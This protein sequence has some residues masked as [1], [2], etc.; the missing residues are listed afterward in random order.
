M[1]FTKTQ[2]RSSSS[3][4][5]EIKKI[6][7]LNIDLFHNGGLWI[8]SLICMI[9]SLS[10]LVSMCKI[11][12]NSHFQTR[13]ERLI[14][15]R[16]N[17]YINRPP[18]WKRSIYS[19]TQTFSAEVHR[20][21]IWVKRWHNK[22]ENSE[23]YWKT[24]LLLK[25]IIIIIIIKVFIQDF[26]HTLKLTMFIS[27]IEPFKHQLQ[28]IYLLTK[29]NRTK[30]QTYEVEERIFGTPCIFIFLFRTHKHLQYITF[31]IHYNNFSLLVTKF[32]LTL[33]QV[34]VIVYRTD[35]KKKRNKSKEKEDKV[36]KNT[37]NSLYNN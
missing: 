24:Q 2:G 8:Y 7:G 18:L 33:K 26:K 12:K 25:L 37:I 27:K 20:S 28:S 23:L 34:T 5:Y 21:N 19:R 14:I 3:S 30:I 10:D 4:G 16:I 11:Q 35:K 13:S 22:Y 1:I 36:H 32:Y 31:A 29:S 6:C 15:I 9:I 17:E